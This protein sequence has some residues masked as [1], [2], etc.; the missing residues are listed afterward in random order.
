MAQSYKNEI[1]FKSDNDAYLFINQ[2]RYYTNGL[3]FHFRHAT[4]QKKLG[5][6]ME[7]L[8]YDF[9][10]GQEM[11]NPYTGFSPNPKT[12][13]RPFAGFLYAQGDLNFFYKKESILTTSLQLGVVGPDAWG[14]EA[15]KF[16]HRSFGFYNIRGW[17]Y[18]IKNTFAANVSVGYSKL[19][20]R[21]TNKNVDLSLQTGIKVGTT[22]NG[23]SAGVLFRAGSINQLFGSASTNAI[24]SQNST[25]K[26][27]VKNEFFFYA[28][29]RLDLVVYDATL[30]GGLFDDNSPITYDPKPIVFSQ[31]IGFDYS[32]QRFTVDFSLLF[33]TREVESDAVAHQYGTISLYYRFSKSATKN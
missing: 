4:D 25:S 24:I 23:A 31:Q 8:I 26:N 32:S 20:H 10:V 12:H 5:Q 9:S 16:L 3:F 2:D 13:D 33:K 18:Q 17:D 19:L 14:E 6:K 7:K 30:Q 27:F 15:Q 1:G 21:M 29:P 22:Y 11:Y 28:K